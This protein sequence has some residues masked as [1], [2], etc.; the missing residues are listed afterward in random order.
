[1]IRAAVHSETMPEYTTRDLDSERP[2]I[3][4][5]LGQASEPAFLCGINPADAPTNNPGNAI[6]S[7]PADLEP[8]RKVW[9]HDEGF[10]TS[11]FSMMRIMARRMR[12]ATVLA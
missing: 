9:I 1:M 7:R 2:L 8:I 12:A 10:A 11:R 5:K 6:G 4:R 3:S